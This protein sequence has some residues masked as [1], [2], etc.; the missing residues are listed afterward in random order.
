MSGLFVLLSSGCRNKDGIYQ[1]GREWIFDAYFYDNNKTLV[2]SVPIKMETRLF[3]SVSFFSWQ[4]GLNYYYEGMEEHTGFIEDKEHIFLHSPRMGRF[5]FTAILP[6]PSMALPP[7]LMTESHIKLTVVKMKG[8]E[9]LNNQVISQTLKRTETEELEYARRKIFCYKSVG[10]NTSHID[11]LGQYKLTYWFHDT[12][13]F[14]RILYEK[15]D[16]TQVDVKLRQTS[17]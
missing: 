4:K 5:A 7:E 10:Y 16:S 1:T 9:E 17:F 3:N 13:G 11:I 8:F 14:V 12:L 15:P 2:D 6:H